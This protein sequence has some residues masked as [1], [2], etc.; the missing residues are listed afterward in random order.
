MLAA[1][2]VLAIS[3]GETQREAPGADAAQASRVVTLAPHLGEMVVAVG[4]LDRLVGVSAYSDFPAELSDLPVVGDAFA[5]DQE[6]LALL[7]PDLVLA[8]ESGTPSETVRDLRQ[9][10]YRVEVVRTRSLVDI[11]AALERIGTMLGEARSGKELAEDFRRAI[12]RLREAHSDSEPIRVYFQISEQPL[13]T[14]SGE[15]YISELIGI[16][17]GLNV[18][19]ELGELAP[20]VSAEAVIVQDPEVML[21][22]V[23]QA[24]ARPLEVWTR[25]PDVAANRYHS[26]FGV[27]AD[28]VG[29]A[30]PR[31]SQAG[32]VICE[33]LETARSRRAEFGGGDDEAG[34]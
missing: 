14:V 8:W 3:C 33:H 10:G 19:D 23:A 2:G 21:S 27:P 4:G 18:F 26:R 34:L 22:S 1:A 16:C 28:L 15:H 32:E 12:S 9:S 30:S 5:V 13:Y 17:G 7:R 31:L 25:W 20:A 11:A 24:D 6:R 29:R